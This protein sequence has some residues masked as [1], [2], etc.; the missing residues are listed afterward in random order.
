M[1]YCS[2]YGENEKMFLY[3][4]T[5]KESSLESKAI[6]LAKENGWLTYKFTSS[7]RGVPDRVFIKNGTVMFVEF[8]SKGKKL[9]KLQEYHRRRI[10]DQNITCLCIDNIDEIELIMEEENIKQKDDG[11]KE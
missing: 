11:N 4:K 3:N 2:H 5:Q 9:S 6:Q 8:K 1:A 7:E 10:S